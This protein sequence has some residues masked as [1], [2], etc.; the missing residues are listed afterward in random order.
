MFVVTKMTFEPAFE[1]TLVSDSDSFMKAL[2]TSVCIIYAIPSAT[3]VILYVLIGARIWN[4]RRLTEAC[5][6]Q[7]ISGSR[8]LAAQRCL[9]ISGNDIN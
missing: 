6:I 4:S 3:I 8:Q 7:N 2:L 1:E 5:R 9:G